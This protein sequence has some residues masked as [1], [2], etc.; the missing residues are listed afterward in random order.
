MAITDFESL[1]EEIASMVDRTDFSDVRLKSFVALV[2]KD[3]RND[4]ESRDSE[5]LVTGTMSG[6]GFTAP[7]GY[8]LTRTLVVAEHFYSYMTPEQYT[9][10]I[11][12]ESTAHVYTINGDTFSVNGG[13]GEDY[14]LLYQSTFAELVDDGDANWVLENAPEIYLWGGCRYAAIYAKDWEGVNTYT[15]LYHE[16]MNKLNRKE[17]QAKVGGPLQVR[18]G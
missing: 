1:R 11:D 9:K 10:V 16:A 17:R 2:E 4:L 7:T 5:Q 13:D 18:P 3:I 6:D 12:Q 15:A 8:L 14:E